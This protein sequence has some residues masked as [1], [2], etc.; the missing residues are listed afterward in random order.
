MGVMDDPFSIVTDGVQSAVVR[1]LAFGLAFLMGVSVG[2]MGLYST[3]SVFLFPLSGVLGIAVGLMQGWGVIGFVMLLACAYMMFFTDKPVSMVMLVTYIIV[4]IE[5]T[6]VWATAYAWSPYP[7]DYMASLL[8]FVILLMPL[9]LFCL[10][11][12]GVSQ[13]PAFRS[14]RYKR[15]MRGECPACGYMIVPSLQAGHD[16]CPE[17]GSVVP[18]EMI[19]KFKQGRL[20]I[21]KGV[22]G[23]PPK[24]PRALSTLKR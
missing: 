18:T 20:D 2:L 6:R 14:K 7:Y 4:A 8:T 17:C 16:V 10:I 21:P 13:D 23:K 1:V 12:F 11:A 3:G 24:H 22:L 15:M 19:Q 9:L 5:Q